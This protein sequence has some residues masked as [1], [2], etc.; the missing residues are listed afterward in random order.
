MFGRDSEK[1]ETDLDNSYP[2]LVRGLSPEF[3]KAD[4]L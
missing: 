1:N 4:R 3:H 2:V